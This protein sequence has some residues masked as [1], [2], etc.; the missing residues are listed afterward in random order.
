MEPGP[1][2]ASMVARRD[3][4]QTLAV[5]IEWRDAPATI[6]LKSLVGY[7]ARLHLLD[8]WMWTVRHPGP[9]P[10]LLLE[11][12][13][14]WRG[15]TGKL[16]QALADAGW[17][18]ESPAGW[19]VLPWQDVLGKFPLAPADRAVAEVAERQ[20]AAV[21][22]RV[23]RYRDRKRQASEANLPVASVTPDVTG[24]TSDVTPVTGNAG[25]MLDI[26][27]KDINNTK[28]RTNPEQSVTVTSNAATEE[29]DRLLAALFDDAPAAPKPRSD[30]DAVWA[31]YAETVPRVRLTKQRQELIKRRL[32]DYSVED[33]VR[34]IR[35]YGKSKFHAGDNDRGIKY[36]T[37]ELWL[38]DAAHVEAGWRYGDQR[39]GKAKT[40]QQR[41]LA[42]I[43]DTWAAYES[44]E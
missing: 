36:Q 18:V 9:H 11:S 40:M 14:L 5:P 41:G 2:A 23:R 43:E 8:L 3:G 33:L 16:I 4:V 27:I 12:A 26:K 35:G 39:D 25:Y 13:A 15:P 32:K 31:A 10:G 44:N 30:V 28:T 24:V 22:E 38:R 20:R 7:D 42:G 19:T 29:S 21:R 37:L 1:E 17:I 34:S 6:L